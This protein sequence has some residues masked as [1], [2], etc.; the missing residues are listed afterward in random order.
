MRIRSGDVDDGFGTGITRSA[1]GSV[2][3]NRLASV[4]VASLTSFL[5]LLQA[6]SGER[7]DR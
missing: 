5:Q 7:R 6:K 3:R 2:F 1:R 4:L